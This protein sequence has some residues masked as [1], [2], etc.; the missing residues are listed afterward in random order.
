M[1][2]TSLV[3]L[4]DDYSDDQRGYLEAKNDGAVHIVDIDEESYTALYNVQQS[5]EA[6]CRCLG[7]SVA[8]GVVQGNRYI[9]LSTIEDTALTPDLEYDSLASAFEIGVKHEAILNT[10]ELTVAEIEKLLGHN[11]KIIKE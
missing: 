7:Y 1:K 8:V 2:T 9:S 11:I 3:L 5:I 4:G 10:K 6:T